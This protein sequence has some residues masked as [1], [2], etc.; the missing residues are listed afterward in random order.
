MKKTDLMAIG[1]TLIVLLD[2][3]DGNF[4]APSTIT[5]VKWCLYAIYIILF[6]YDKFKCKVK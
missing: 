4:T 1:A 5:K 3:F 2:F 6:L